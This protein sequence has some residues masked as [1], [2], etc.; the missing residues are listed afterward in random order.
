[1][2]VLSGSQGELRYNGTELSCRAWTL[3]TTQE[4]RETT[5]LCSSNRTYLYGQ[6]DGTGE[7]TVLY[8]SDDTAA[9][10]MLNS[11][12]IDGASEDAVTF[13]LDGD[14]S[15]QYVRTAFVTSVS[16]SVQVGA[17]HACR[18][19]FQLSD[20]AAII[21]ITGPD[22]VQVNV[23]RQYFSAVSG[24]PAGRVIGYEWTAMGA[25]FSPSNAVQ[26][27]LVTFDTVGTVTLKVTATLDDQSTI[28]D[29]LDVNVTTDP[30]FWTS[31]RMTPLGLGGQNY[32]VTARDELNGWA[33]CAYRLLPFDGGPEYWV[34]EKRNAANG[35][36][37]NTWALKRVDNTDVPV[38]KWPQRILIEPVSRDLVILVGSNT[39]SATS[40]YVRMTSSGGL[41]WFGTAVNLGQSPF[42]LTPS[43]EFSTD[44]T[45]LYDYYSRRSGVL[46]CALWDMS[47]PFGGGASQV[48]W[49]NP[50]N[51]F[52]VDYLPS[53]TS[54]NRYISAGGYASGHAYYEFAP[55]LGTDP[56]NSGPTLLSANGISEGSL[57]AG[58][59]KIPHGVSV[60]LGYHAYESGGSG[61]TNLLTYQADFE[62]VNRFSWQGGP[63]FGTNFSPQVANN[64]DW[65]I[66]SE[67]VFS[68]GNRSLSGACAI[69]TNATSEGM[70]RNICI[71]RVGGAANFNGTSPYGCTKSF[72]DD[73]VV[74]VYRS[75][76]SS[77]LE[78]CAFGYRL[79]APV[80]SYGIL[81]GTDDGA[82]PT[83]ELVMQVDDATGR[84]TAP[85]GNVV[86]SR[87]DLVLPGFV[88]ETWPT[89]IQEFTTEY[90]IEEATG[91]TYQQGTAF[92]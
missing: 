81:V 21:Q 46:G 36:V 83:A 61:Q 72:V 65:W 17:A 60:G 32:A 15:T 12:F 23:T 59:F 31:R 73:L 30:I 40:Y 2:T 8:D 25:T 89:Y 44:G 35:T 24:I 56:F 41:V 51:Q 49:Y 68:N 91:F 86:G 67:G 39:A 54:D 78:I 19:S 85:V 34:I 37:L 90:I 71:E 27:P 29:T 58:V 57:S 26:N 13:V 79:G 6:I 88:Q 53:R 87:T 42:A 16:T 5:D 69:Q 14:N 9:V 4:S 77:S 11:V 43:A 63:W 84:N 48:G 82:D 18:V 22:E 70:T 66:T 80:G 52:G 20:T 38:G 3:N 92:A 28:E 55:D 64:Q 47:D 7:A 10:E 75:G 62:P 76:P 33:Y 1:M 45:Y 50:D 74:G